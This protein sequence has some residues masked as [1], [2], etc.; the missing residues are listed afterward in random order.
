MKST[1]VN[2]PKRFILKD[3][4]FEKFG[5]NNIGALVLV[6]YMAYADCYVAFRHYFNMLVSG[7]DKYEEKQMMKF[8]SLYDSDADFLHIDFRIMFF[9]SSFH[10]IYKNKPSLSL[11]LFETVCAVDGNTKFV[12]CKNCE[13][14]FVPVGQS[15]SVCCGYL[16]P[17]DNTEA[18]RGV[19]TNATR[20]RKMKNNI[21]TQEY[22]RLYL[23]LNVE[24]KRHPKNGY[25]INCR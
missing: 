3:T 13:K 4:E 20:A 21:L 24:I 25:T 23:R 6:A 9:D 12:K 8:W 11:I 18:C 22:R 16:F 5:I 1:F 14:Y 19:G 7:E 15:D 17:Q 10:T 2:V